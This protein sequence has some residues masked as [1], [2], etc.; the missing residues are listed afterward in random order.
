MGYHTV[1]CVAFI[2]V[3]LAALTP[4]PRDAFAAWISRYEKQA[5]VTPI[6]STDTD[7]I[8][9]YLWALLPNTNGTD[10]CIFCPGTFLFL[11]CQVL[12]RQPRVAS[13]RRGENGPLPVSHTD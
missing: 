9:C 10:L 2:R 8:R 12:R 4:A 6:G 13:S 3:D 11:H 7:F 5:P 1:S